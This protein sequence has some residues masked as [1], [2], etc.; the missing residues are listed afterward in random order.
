MRIELTKAQAK[1]ALDD[2]NIP[3][4]FMIRLNFAARV[5]TIRVEDESRQEA[6]L[7]YVKRLSNP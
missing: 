5:F 2:P 1:A 7:Q 4:D 6:L 3:R